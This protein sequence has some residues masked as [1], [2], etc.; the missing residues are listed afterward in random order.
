MQSE[1]PFPVF[2]EGW[3]VLDTSS[4]LPVG[5]ILKKKFAGQEIVLFRTKSGEVSTIDAYCPHMGAHFGYGGKVEGETIRCPFH[6]FCFNTKGECDSTPYG[7]KVPPLAKV[8]TFPTQEKNGFILVYYHPEGRQPNWEV[9]ALDNQDWTPVVAHT[10]TLK[11][12]PQETTENSVDVGHFAEVHDFFGVEML[13]DLSTE[14]PYLNI[15]YK[16]QRAAMKILG[17]HLGK[18]SFSFDVHVH[19]LGYS[20]VD[21][22]VGGF[23]SIARNFVFAT[24]YD[25]TNI[26]LTIAHSFR[27][28]SKEKHPILARILPVD[29]FAKL[30]RNIVFHAYKAEVYSDFDIWQHKKYVQPPLLAKGDGPIG[31]YRKWCKQFYTYEGL[32]H[33]ALPPANKKAA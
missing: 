24:P 20:F 21:V 9:P 26:Q 2:P 14:G 32:T 5:G 10:W 8:K 7:G 4:E 31:P 28:M 19:G 33:P 6:G 1:Y 22:T 16:A 25:G 12:H 30:I 13:K 17:Q 23:K 15:E 29:L 27:K 18:F 3:Y 11:G